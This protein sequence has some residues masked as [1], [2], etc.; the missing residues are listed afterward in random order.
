MARDDGDDLSA[1]ERDLVAL[2]HEMRRDKGELFWAGL[3][4][5]IGAAHGQALQRRR[6]KR[7]TALGAAALAAGLL[8][9]IRPGLR[10]PLPPTAPVSM[11]EELLDDADPGELVE[12]LDDAE[13]RRLTARMTGSNEE[14]G[15]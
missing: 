14:D 8:L 13:V 15:T 4:K 3:A 9:W 2:G 10:G 7:W 1:L 11:T 12:T 6:R 5:K